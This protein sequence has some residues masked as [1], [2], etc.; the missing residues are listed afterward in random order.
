MSYGPNSGS[1]QIDR[2]ELLA[3]RSLVGTVF[4]R[5]YSRRVDEWL[6]ALFHERLGDR[7]GISLVALGGYGRGTLS[8][9]SDLDVMLLHDGWREADLEE[10]AQALWF[11]VWD[12]KIALGHS[13]RTIPQSIE[14]AETDLETATSLLSLRHLAGNAELSDDLVEESARRWRKNRRQWIPQIVADARARE[15]TN[16]EVAYLLEPDLKA[17]SGGLR[18]INAVQWIEAAGVDTLDQERRDLRAAND[19]LLAARV[20]LHRGT[21]RKGDI[22]LL[23]EQDSVAAALG[24]EDAD[25]MMSQVAASART[26]NWIADDVFNRSNNSL[27]RFG[28]RAKKPRTVADHVVLAEGSVSIAPGAPVGNDQGLLLRLA[29]AAAEREARIDRDS[30]DLLVELGPPIRTPWPP[31]IRELFVRLLRTGH[32]AIPVVEA[33]DHVGL[34][35]RLFPEWE[36]TRSKVQRNQYHRFTVD[37]HLLEASSVASE[38]TDSVDRPDL[39]VVGALLHDIGKGYPGDHTEVG[40]MLIDTIATN[41]GFDADDVDTLKRMCEHHLLLPDVATRR[42]IQDP[43]TIAVVAE[44]VRTPAFLHLL[45]ALTEADSI[46]TG[47][48][49]WTR[50]KA[51]LTAE[52]TRSTERWL[53]TGGKVEVESSFPGEDHL[54]L[55]ASTDHA[56]V[57]GGDTLQVVT[58]DRPGLFARVAGAL[59]LK[60]LSIIEAQIHVEGN[61]ALEVFQVVDGDD[62]NAAIDWLDA[63][64][65]IEEIL[66]DDADLTPRFE[67]RERSILRRAVQSPRPIEEVRVEFDNDVSAESTVIEVA[68][69]DRV[70]LLYE[71]SSALAAAGLDIQQARV[72]TVGGD[73]VDSFYVQ[74]LHGQKII[75]AE[76]Q[77]ALRTKLLEILAPPTND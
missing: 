59:A 63:V 6:Q 41:M 30:L 62:E 55:L 48:S 20:E 39:L 52:L 34:F 11:P 57:G 35:V 29:V 40:V 16:G 37:R 71:V 9:Q 53:E 61:K 14:L 19:V 72:Q 13:V 10:A 45:A 2:E 43:G 58:G 4:C 42:D 12:A 28:F 3:D 73:V 69:L 51:H 65:L 15:R 77:S 74:T 64:A 25:V 36:P 8:P 33:L 54:A 21:L 7:P 75:A 46:A 17:A 22:L 60:N 50:N 5:A 26:V 66:A 23:E 56:V 24:V 38:L 31:E 68:G 27:R 18:D 44:Q 32:R 76:D 67:A 47:P 1:P 49:A 70:G